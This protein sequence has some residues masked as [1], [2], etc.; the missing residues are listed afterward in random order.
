MRE[1]GQENVPPVYGGPLTIAMARSKLDEHKL[2]DVELCD[3]APGEMLELG[4]VFA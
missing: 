4:A 1:L 2:R 3:V